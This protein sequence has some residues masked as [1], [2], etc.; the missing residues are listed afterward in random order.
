[1]MTVV[2]KRDSDGKLL[3]FTKGAESS[4]FP[5][6]VKDEAKLT[7][8]SESVDQYARLGYRTLVFAMKELNAPE[9]SI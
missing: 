5:R 4:L 1:M 7:A 8:C 2:V 3:V 6:A 9:S